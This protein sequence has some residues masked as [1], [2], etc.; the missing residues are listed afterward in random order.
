MGAAWRGPKEKQMEV[1]TEMIR[2]VK[3]LGMETCV[4]LGMLK[5]GQA[6]Q[7]KEASLHLVPFRAQEQSPTGSPGS[8]ASALAVS[9]GPVMTSLFEQVTNP[10]TLLAA[11]RTILAHDAEDGEVQRQSRNAAPKLVANWR[12]G[13]NSDQKADG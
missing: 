11:W 3:A 4:T 9:D 12:I 7:L 1:V 6:E 10:L 13:I 2:E 5:E 8:Q